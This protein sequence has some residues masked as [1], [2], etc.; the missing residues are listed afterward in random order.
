MDDRYFLTCPTMPATSTYTATGVCVRAR[1]G[2]ICTLEC[3]S[4]L[5]RI[6][7]SRT[8]G[9]L[10]T[11]RSALVGGWVG[12]GWGVGGWG[13]GGGWVG[14]GGGGGGVVCLSVERTAFVVG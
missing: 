13:V 4:P 14:G 10:H 11:L 9:A 7:G 12:G 3:I 2:D 6:A 1:D 5:Q 8:S